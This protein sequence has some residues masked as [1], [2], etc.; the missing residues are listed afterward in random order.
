MTFAKGQAQPLFYVL[1]AVGSLTALMTA[2]YMTRMMLYTF[3]GPN[4]AGQ[5]E[6]EHLHEAPW[7]MTGPLVVLGI[8]AALGGL[9]NLPEV[10]PGAGWLHHWLEPVTSAGDFYVVTGELGH[11]TEWLLLGLATLVAVAGMLAA[12]RLLAPAALRPA[13][14]AA[15]ETGFEKILLK[16]W[17]VDEIYDRVFVRPLMWLSERVLWKGVDDGA[18]DTVGVNGSARLARG[19]GAVGSWLQTGHVTTYV[20]FFVVGVLLLLRAVTGT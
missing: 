17:Y 10:L 5:A 20:F 13:A 11:R 2:F 4:R 6:R 9:L 15:P 7:V 18:I 16:K 14:E 19:V 12:W 1:W 8:G 3:H